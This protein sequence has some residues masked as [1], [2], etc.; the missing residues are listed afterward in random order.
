MKTLLLTSFCA[1]W[2]LTLLAAPGTPI[3]GTGLA[4]NGPGTVSVVTDA[5]AIR[6]I[7]T[8]APAGGLTDIPSELVLI[9]LS[10]ATGGNAKFTPVNKADNGTYALL[11]E[12]SPTKIDVD[13]GQAKGSGQLPYMAVN[14]SPI[15][16]MFKGMS[17]VG[18]VVVLNAGAA[19][20]V[21]IQN[22]SKHTKNYSPALL[23]DLSNEPGRIHSV[24]T[25]GKLKRLHSNHGGFGGTSATDPGV[26]AIGEAS[27]DGEIKANPKGHVSFVLLCAGLTPS[28]DYD[29]AGAYDACIQSNAVLPRVVMGSLKMLNAK[30]IGPAV[31]G[32]TFTKRIPAQQIGTRVKLTQPVVGQD[33][34]V[35]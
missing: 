25:T 12:G 9:I 4:Y 28:H 13:C 14:G 11:I 2:A 33:N 7:L 5:G 10:N 15:K 3:P 6:D 19:A 1:L 35:R 31:I 23:G 34:L 17:R 29:Y 22:I 16:I 26:I 18:K 32:A 21:H 27:P 24:I 20:G 30:E 8:N